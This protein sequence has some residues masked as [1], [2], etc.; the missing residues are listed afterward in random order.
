MGRDIKVYIKR[1]RLYFNDSFKLAHGS[2]SFRENLFFIV[3]YDGYWGMGEAPV[4]PYYGHTPE[5]IEEDLKSVGKETLLELIE[6]GKNTRTDWFIPVKTMTAGNAVETAMSDIISQISER[7]KPSE[8]NTGVVTGYPTSFTV[9]GESFKEIRTKVEGSPSRVIKLKAGV[10]NDLETAENIRK[11]FPDLTLRIDV[12]QGWTKEEAVNKLKYLYDMG[13]ELVEE[14]GG[15]SLEDIEYIAAGSRIPVFLDE[16]IQT[17]FDLVALAEKA[18]SVKGVVVKLAKAGGPNKALSMI[19]R[20]YDLGLEV[21]LSSMV[22]SSAGVHTA[23]NLMHICRYI[24]LDSPLL[25]KNDPFN[26]VSY[27][28]GKIIP[29]PPEDRYKL[30]EKFSA[31]LSEDS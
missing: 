22:E 7:I 25:L 28:E 15:N 4:V 23:S 29:V 14:P 18:P 9:S 10:G 1:K 30:I 21:M 26:M 31:E 13:I 12:N 5:M 11:F 2:Y 27:Y 20:A 8:L 3:Y 6:S 17:E 19:R 24:D 16:S